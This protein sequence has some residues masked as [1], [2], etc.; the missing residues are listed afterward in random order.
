M[1]YL[2]LKNVFFFGNSFRILSLDGWDWSRTFLLETSLKLKTCLKNQPLRKKRYTCHHLPLSAK[3]AGP[4]ACRVCCL[5]MMVRSKAMLPKILNSPE[6]WPWWSVFSPNMCLGEFNGESVIVKKSLKG[7]FADIC[8]VLGQNTPPIPF[9]RNVRRTIAQKLEQQ[10]SYYDMTKCGCILYIHIYI[11]IFIIYTGL[12]T[13][14]FV[15]L[16]AAGLWA[17]C[18]PKIC[19]AKKI[20]VFYLSTWYLQ[21]WTWLMQEIYQEP[22]P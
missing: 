9:H 18:P 3:P 1:S 13:F 19:L 10:L 4:P 2:P 7:L 17:D 8:C 20:T 6:C 22:I 16:V 5:C 12:N 21:D 15:V 11:H 14:I